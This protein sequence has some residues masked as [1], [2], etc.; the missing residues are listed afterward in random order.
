MK[1]E[2]HEPLEN[3]INLYKKASYNLKSKTNEFLGVAREFSYFQEDMLSEFKRNN[4][5]K[6][7]RDNGDLKEFDITNFLQSNNLL[8]KKYGVS[9]NK[10]RI[11][12]TSGHI[13]Q[14]MDVVF[15]DY[16]NN[17]ELMNRKG[18]YKV[19]PV[20]T[21]YG[22]MQV[23]S[24][25]TKRELKK[26]LENIASY[27]RLKRK[28]I[29]CEI[30]M[31]K[32]KSDRGFGILFAYD[33]DLEWKDI[34]N[35]T[36]LF[37]QNNPKEHWCNCIVILNRGI[38]VY[39]NEKFGGIYNLIHDNTNEAQVYGNNSSTDNLYML[40]TNIL[41]L[42]RTTKVQDV[43]VTEYCVL[44]YTCGKYSYK[45][46]FGEIDEFFKCK[47]HGLYLKKIKEDKLENIIQYCNSAEPVNLWKIIIDIAQ[48]KEN[49]PDQYKQ[50]INSIYIYNPENLEYDKILFR[51]DNSG[52]L[53]INT[54]I[55]ENK[56]ICIPDY[57]AV[58]DD[59]FESCPKCKKTSC[60]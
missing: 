43:D 25:L 2:K 15:Y 11:A 53:A 38:I 33:S 14:E 59:I 13:S 29:Q 58:K 32:P 37:A 49:E 52:C 46:Q 54:I 30:I 18:Q 51:L 50:D 31:G 19:F 57:Y 39:G 26:G 24:K 1:K 34:I 7:V 8:P 5:I 35:E 60:K 20:E 22:V 56:T 41:E 10:V 17:I 40:Y 3:T 28:Q 45:F 27:K 42:L 55:C 23:K 48:N 16:F 36:R 12:S 44:P 21:V 4:D 47:K 6:H 9:G